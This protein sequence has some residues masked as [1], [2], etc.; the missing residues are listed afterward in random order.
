MACARPGTDMSSP[1]MSRRE[2][3]TWGRPTKETETPAKQGQ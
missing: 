2:K 3:S 1:P